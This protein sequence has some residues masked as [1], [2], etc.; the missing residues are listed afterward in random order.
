MAWNSSD[1][2]TGGRPGA[3]P[4][5]RGERAVVGSSISVNGDLSGAEDLLVLGRVEGKIDVADNTV[6]VGQ[7]GRVR[8]D[9]H[10]AVVVIE[11]DVE[12]N[13][14]GAERVVL[15]ASGNVKGNLT[16]PKVLIEDGARFEGTVDMSQKGRP[17]TK[18][19]PRRASGGSA[20]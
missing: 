2:P 18:S 20:G 14:F 19:E 4:R 16:A 3:T 7:G 8:A 5:D 15:R 9:I 1:E 11:G 6:T 17:A 13:L 12:G 10:G